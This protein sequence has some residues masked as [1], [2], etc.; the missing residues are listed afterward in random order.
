[1]SSSPFDLFVALYEDPT[2]HV[3]L[4]CDKFAKYEMRQKL[5]AS[6]FG[7]AEAAADGSVVLFCQ[8][9]TDKENKEEENEKRDLTDAACYGCGKKGHLRHKRPDK[10]A[11][12]E[13]EKERK[14]KP[15]GAR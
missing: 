9:T 12:N 6:R 14:R 8:Q 2:H 4:L 11:E 1:M 15:D 10:K 7:N 13:N 3:D 5:R